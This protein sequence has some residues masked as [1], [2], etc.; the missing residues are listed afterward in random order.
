VARGYPLV[1][2]FPSYH[3]EIG[4]PTAYPKMWA[5]TLALTYSFH[6]RREANADRHRRIPMFPAVEFEAGDVVEVGMKN[7]L[8]HCALLRVPLDDRHDIVYVLLRPEGDAAL[9][10]TMWINA[11]ND[12]HATL[13]RETYL[14]P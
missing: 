13:K 4:I 11:A 10:M 3:R 6:A 2:D 12:T 9:V 7:G 8:P 1:K 14:R 5:G